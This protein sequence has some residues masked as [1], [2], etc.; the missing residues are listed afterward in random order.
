MRLPVTKPSFFTIWLSGIS[1]GMWIGVFVHF[2]SNGYLVPIQI[3]LN[4][5]QRRMQAGAIGE[6]IKRRVG[7]RHVP[8]TCGKAPSRHPHTS[9]SARG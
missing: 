8:W 5:N 6:L 2:H 9:R 1:G 3:E 7:A 4:V